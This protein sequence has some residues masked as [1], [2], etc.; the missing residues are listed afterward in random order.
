MSSTPAHTWREA[1]S[2]S[3]AAAALVHEELQLPEAW[4]GACFSLRSQV[5]IQI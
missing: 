5:G 2:A 1:G 3:L 4:A